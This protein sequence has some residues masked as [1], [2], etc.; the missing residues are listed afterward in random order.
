MD[1][2]QKLI[3]F[4]L[5][6]LDIKDKKSATFNLKNV[7]MPTVLEMESSGDYKAVNIP[8]EGKE[9]TS[10]KGGFQ[11]VAGSVVPALNRLERRIGKQDWGKELR[12]HKDASKLSPEQ[13]QL[14]FMADMLEKDGSD[15]YMIKVMQG[16]KKGSMEAYYKLHHTAPDEATIKRANEIFGEVYKEEDMSKKEP[17]GKGILEEDGDNYLT[18]YGSGIIPKSELP[19]MQQANQVLSDE[20]GMGFGL[21]QVMYYGF[22]LR[23]EK[24]K[25]VE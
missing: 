13:Q 11:F 21:D 19:E 17:T 23:K 4:H 24:N 12:Q 8:Q 1:D 2:M 16:D 10:A 15:Q 20:V 14:L 5:D 3:N 7:F 6:R 18:N 25:E 22:N 9:A